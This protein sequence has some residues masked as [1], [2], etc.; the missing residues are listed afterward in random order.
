MCRTGRDEFS[1]AMACSYRRTSVGAGNTACFV[2]STTPCCFVFENHLH[3]LGSI[4]E[5]S[6]V[7]LAL[8]GKNAGADRIRDQQHIAKVIAP[9]QVIPAVKP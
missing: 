8:T 9:A 4:V 6:R 5:V 3:P 7:R 1:A 2:T